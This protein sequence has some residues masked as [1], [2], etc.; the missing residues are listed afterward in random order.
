MLREAEAYN[1]KLAS[2]ESS[3]YPSAEELEEYNRT[4]DVSGTGM[5][6][7]LEIPKIGV[8]LPVYHTVDDEVL[9]V[10]VGHIPG[11]SLPVGGASTHSVVSGHTGLPSATLLTELDKL[12]EGDIF[13]VKVLNRTLT[14]QVDQIKKVLPEETSDLAIVPEQDYFTLVT[15]TP[16]GVNSH[17]LLVHGERCEYRAADEAV[18]S[19]PQVDRRLAPALIGTA[20]AALALA[21]VAAAA[22]ARRRHGGAAH[23]KTQS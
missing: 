18:E 15:C 2:G 13:L 23:L 6:G 17:R 7:Y 4:L 11:S 3:F 1:Q 22:F 8:S 20:I 12:S 19:A 14:Y 10:G 21:A 16:Y 5:M 9:K